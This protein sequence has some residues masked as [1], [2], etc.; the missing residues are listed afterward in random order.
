MESTSSINNNQQNPFIYEKEQHQQQQNNGRRVKFKLKNS[1]R[2]TEK[3]INNFTSMDNQK[4]NKL[5][6]NE[7]GKEEIFNFALKGLVEELKM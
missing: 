1:K 6:N 4:N 7:N 2:K 5:I 3:I